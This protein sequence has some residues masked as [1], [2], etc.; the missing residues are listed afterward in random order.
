MR[1]KIEVISDVL[2]EISKLGP[3][4]DEMTDLTEDREDER[5]T[6]EGRNRQRV[7]T[8]RIALLTFAKQW[9]PE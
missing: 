1:L 9:E 8:V 3:L 7:R 6:A 2:H 4:L 5:E